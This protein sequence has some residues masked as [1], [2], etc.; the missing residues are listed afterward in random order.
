ML[1]IYPINCSP[2]LLDESEIGSICYMQ[3]RSRYMNVFSAMSRTLDGA[4]SDCQSIHRNAAYLSKDELC[5]LQKIEDR[6]D[7]NIQ[8]F[9][10]CGS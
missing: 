8:I 1:D 10:A 6:Y 5:G 2:F 9:I 4:K 3:S 7:L